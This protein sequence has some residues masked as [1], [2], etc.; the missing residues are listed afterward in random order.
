[1]VV[2]TIV[3]ELEPR[4]ASAVL[5]SFRGKFLAAISRQKGFVNARMARR[6]DDPTR[7]L[8]LIYFETEQQR[9]DWVA[10]AAHEPAWNS[11]AALCDRFTAL[12][13]EI[14]ASAREMP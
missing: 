6:L 3:L 9:L 1:M 12:P 4:N 5:D 2:L 14:L 7:M 8:M 11:I 13:H 10:S